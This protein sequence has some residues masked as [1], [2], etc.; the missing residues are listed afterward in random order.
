MVR[1]VGSSLFLNNFIL[2][3]EEAKTLI[4]FVELS[5]TRE[6]PEKNIFGVEDGG[7]AGTGLAR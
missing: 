1:E 7:L 5:R 2:W 4:R 3:E 6:N